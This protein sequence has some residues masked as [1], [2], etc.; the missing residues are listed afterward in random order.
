MQ[1]SELP[2]GVPS[3][4][5]S[6]VCVSNSVWVAIVLSV[7]KLFI[8]RYMLLYSYIS[9]LDEETLPPDFVIGRFQINKDSDR[10]FVHLESSLYFLCE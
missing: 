4:R 1:L 7:R 6:F 9:H 5:H 8:H 10:V 3:L 2:C